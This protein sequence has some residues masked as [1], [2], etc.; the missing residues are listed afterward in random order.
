[1]LSIGGVLEPSAWGTHESGGSHLSWRRVWEGLRAGDPTFRGP[2]GVGSE[3]VRTP[4]FVI[5]LDLRE[6]SASPL[7]VGVQ[8]R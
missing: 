1:M 5:A 3:T 7:E 2:I 4:G 8:A 6:E